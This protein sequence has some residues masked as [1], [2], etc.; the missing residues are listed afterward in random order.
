[1]KTTIIRRFFQLSIITLFIVGNRYGIEIISGNL[2]SSLLFGKINLS[3]PFAVIQL[4]LSGLFINLT[5]LTSAMIVLF[6][7]AITFPRAFCSF[8]C[9]IN[10]LTDT[11][12]FLRHKFNINRNFLRLSPNLRYYLLILALIFSL[13]FK[14]PAFESISYVS[15]FTRSLVYLSF[16]AFTIAILII[17]FETFVTKRGICSYICPLGAF[18]AVISKFSLFRIKHN[19]IN[20]TNC[21]K[22]KV[23][24]PESRVLNLIGKESGYIGSECISCIRCIEV[25]D[26]D[27]LNFSILKLG[28]KR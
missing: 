1:M 25:C 4:F 20:C 9:P 24:C 17:A 7:Y 18:Y 27:A 22:C 10:L 5:A 16:D 23:V 15:A 21:N 19:H 8:V 3:D 28:E 13:V 14:L 26:D 6:F 12:A 11:G 2:S